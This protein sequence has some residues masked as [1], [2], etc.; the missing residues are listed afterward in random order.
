[1]LN[2]LFEKYLAQLLSPAWVSRK[3]LRCCSS[4]PLKPCAGLLVGV[5]LMA[6]TGFVSAESPTSQEINLALGKPYTLSPTPN[7]KHCTDP[8]DRTQ[9]TDGIKAGANWIKKSTV[10]WIDSWNGASR[11]ATITI[12]LGRVEPIGEVR[13]C[14]VGGGRVGVFAPRQ[15]LVTV[16]DDGRSYYLAGAA[17][18]PIMEMELAE[19]GRIAKSFKFRATNINSCGRYVRIMLVSAGRYVFLDEIEVFA[20]DRAT[21]EVGTQ[22]RVL[23]T[24]DRLAGFLSDHRC[25]VRACW[26]IER[27]VSDMKSGGE[28][29]R[30][31]NPEQL[32]SAQRLHREAKQVAVDQ[33]EKIRELQRS[34]QRLRGQWLNS[35]GGQPLRWYQADAMYQL[36]PDDVYGSPVSELQVARLEMWVGEYEPLALTVVNQQP[37]DATFEVAISLLQNEAGQ[38]FPPH[39]TIT[40]RRAYFVETIRAGLIGDALV[41]ITDGCWTVEAG[42]VGQLWLTLHNPNLPDGKYH[43]G[44][45]LRN[46]VEK[47]PRETLIPVEVIVH[48][49]RFPE[50][51]TLKSYN[52][53]YLTMLGLERHHIPFAVHDLREHYINVNILPLSDLPIGKIRLGSLSVDFGQHDRALDYYPDAALFLFF[54]ACSPQRPDGFGRGQW[55]PYMSDPWKHYFRS[56][57]NQWVDHLRQR[58]IG[59]DRFALYPY[60][61]SLCDEFLQL[62][63]FIKQID[64]HIRIFANSIGHSKEYEDIKRFAD[65]IDIWCLPQPT[66]RA[67]VAASILREQGPEEIWR[68]AA[69]SYARGA[70]TPYAYYRKM[71]WLA[72]A[73]GDTGCGFWVYT[74]RRQNT[75]CASWDDFGCEAE[76]CS[77]VYDGRYAPVDCGGEIMVPSR[78]WEA[79]R[80]GVEDYEY[81]V[82]LRKEL[83]VAKTN[84]GGITYSTRMQEVIEDLSRKITQES[85]RPE[86]VYQ[87]RQ[88]ITAKILHLHQE[89]QRQDPKP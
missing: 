12:D 33:T 79:W 77:V 35:R 56:Y 15:L 27:L 57:L 4:Q 31:A 88:R 61:E 32:E 11:Y 42:S 52:W 51:V 59:Y 70:L 41:K 82:Q 29:A 89:R 76:R 65:Y 25:L 87:A 22:R 43:F 86:Q 1:M 18:N 50:R 2:L 71:P 72:W 40:L 67:P 36:R 49:L 45:R 8:E 38:T 39:E 16:S 46:T 20:G 37:E 28:D 69:A 24:A 3:A 17:H 34:V 62:A 10:G 14:S 7:Y 19:P 6:C 54:A 68:Y 64:P 26:E 23:A 53:A 66:S 55:N 58:G 30:G 44:V 60:D 63:K 85:S 48:P 78:R 73:D 21:A 80:E 81:L 5:L 75:P 13:V 9:L 47:P 74:D 84:Q 83:F